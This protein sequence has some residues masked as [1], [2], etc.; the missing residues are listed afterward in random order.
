MNPKKQDMNCEECI[1]KHEAK[2]ATARAKERHDFINDRI[3]PAIDK[4]DER[5][6]GNSDEIRDLDKDVTLYH[7]IT[8]TMQE[9]IK[10][11]KE[12]MKAFIES[13]DKKYATK[14]ALSRIDKLLWTFWVAIVLWMWWVIWNLIQKAIVW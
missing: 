2:C 11:I 14:E 3:Q 10:E 1:S 6:S 5:I 12:V 4:L 7:Q 8:K 13:A 9:D